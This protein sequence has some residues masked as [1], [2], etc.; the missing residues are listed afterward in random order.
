M[1]VRLRLMNRKPDIFLRGCQVQEK[2]TLTRLW[3]KREEYYYT[4]R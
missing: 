1:R 2:S 3:R 4:E